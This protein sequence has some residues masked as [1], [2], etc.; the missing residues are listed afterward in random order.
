MEKKKGPCTIVTNPKIR[1]NNDVMMPMMGAGVWGYGDYWAER[2]VLLAFAAGITHIDTAN[3]YHNQRGVGRA[4]RRSGKEREEYFLTSKVPGCGR[5]NAGNPD[6]CYEWTMSFLE[7]DMRLLNS[8]DERKSPPM[9]IHKATK[10]M[11][12]N[13]GFSAVKYH[14][15][16]GN[17]P[18]SMVSASRDL[19]ITLQAYSPLG[20]GDKFF[21]EGVAT[22]EIGKK[23]GKTAAQIALKWVIQNGVPVLTKSLNPV[24]LAED[25]D[26]FD[27]NLTDPDMQRLS[28]E[29]RYYTPSG[30]LK[31][32]K[33][34]FPVGAIVGIFIATI[35]V[36]T[37]VVIL[38]MRRRVYYQ[39]FQKFLTMLRGRSSTSSLAL[40]S[41]YREVHLESRDFDEYEI[42]TQQ[43]DAGGVEA[44]YNGEAEDA[45]HRAMSGQIDDDDDDHDDDDV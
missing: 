2:G 11:A 13:G 37:L 25:I 44:D 15:G 12:R 21:T 19:G 17:D 26:I 31:D 5:Q 23:Y 4:L 20:N 33:K 32:G 40:G 45:L 27:F 34:D 18:F 42:G 30:C 9:Y 3:D 22:T 8:D 6:D 1:L 24:Y 36:V 28:D 39:K 43:R 14:I 29:N 16:M 41:A 35:F 7:E 10:S 38:F